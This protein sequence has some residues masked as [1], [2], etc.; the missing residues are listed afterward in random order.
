MGEM[1]MTGKVL[2]HVTMSLDGFIAG[3]GD[4]MDWIFNV[5]R[6]EP[7]PVAAE[8]IRITG[9]ILAGRLSWLPWSSVRR[10]TLFRRTDDHGSHDS[11]RPASAQA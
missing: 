3:P 9:A 10:T 7:S 5:P 2:Y 1:G 4:A 8:V 6:A 11:R